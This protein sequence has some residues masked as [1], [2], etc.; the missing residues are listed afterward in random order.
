MRFKSLPIFFS[1]FL[2][3]S[4]IFAQTSAITYQ[5]VLS[6]GGA[7]ANGTYQMQFSL[8]D[9]VS[10]GTQV[11]STIT[12]TSVNVANGI[13]T[14][15]LDFSPATPFSAGANRFLQVAVKKTAEPS[16]TTLAPRQQITSS[17]YS[18]R[19]LSA[20]SSDS[21]SSACV[22]CVTNAQINSIDGSKVTGSTITNI[23]ATNLSSGTVSDARL[24]TNVTL[25]GN[26]FNGA[27]Q[28]VKLD[29]TSKLPA[30]DGSQLTN[31]SAP[32]SPGGFVTFAAA[33]GN[34]YA[35]GTVIGNLATRTFIPTLGGISGAGVTVTFTLPPAN[36]YPA[37]TILRVY[38]ADYTTSAPTFQF[39]R[40]ASTSDLLHGF[41]QGTGVAG[42]GS[43]G[44]VIIGWVTDGSSNWYRGN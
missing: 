30:V 21:L 33:N 27:N 18:L 43:F 9:A 1:L 36:S 11:G 32:S 39:Q 3:A 23:N 7:P 5:G 44:T 10:A 22:G 42:P 8:F 35:L 15:Q 6:D 2:F 20:S 4:S 17:P 26:T 16:Y 31:I 28:L 19:T 14:V 13:F 38:V 40:T 34:T 24:S 12:N 25:Q 41:N 29:G 37:G